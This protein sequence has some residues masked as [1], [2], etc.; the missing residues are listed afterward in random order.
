M[1]IQIARSLPGLCNIQNGNLPDPGQFYRIAI[2]IPPLY[3]PGKDRK[4]ISGYQES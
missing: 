1:L 2:P 3:I 4:G